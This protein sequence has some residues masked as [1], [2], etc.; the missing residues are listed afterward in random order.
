M[1]MPA[2]GT[3][4][5]LQPRD[6]IRAANSVFSRADAQALVPTLMST[7]ATGLSAA[8]L[9]ERLEWLWLMRRDVTL[10]ALDVALRGRLLHRPDERT[11]SEV[12]RFLET[13]NADFDVE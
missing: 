12:I 2:T 13:F 4:R 11:L 6:V 9:T 7:Y 10:R 1:L 5:T 3:R 8:D